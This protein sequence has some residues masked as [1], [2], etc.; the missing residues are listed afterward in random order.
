MTITTRDFGTME[1]DEQELVEF[2]APIFGFESL[3]KFA[4]LS[5][6]DD[7][8]GLNWL[9]S[10]EDPDI[11]FVLLDPDAVGLEYKPKIPKDTMNALALE[12]YPALRLIVVVPEDFHE[13]TANMKSPLLFN[14]HKKLAAQVILEDD[15]PIRMP[16]FSSEEG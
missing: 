6:D 5:D 12:D 16:L 4:I 2:V 13:T 7:N 11:C 9:Q 3:R 10:V 15:Y 14:P 8:S 1:L